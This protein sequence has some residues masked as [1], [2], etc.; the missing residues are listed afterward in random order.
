MGLIF[1]TTEEYKLL[2]FS[3]KKFLYISRCFTVFSKYIEI[4]NIPDF[5]LD[6][7]VF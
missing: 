2:K 5:A 3:S 6:M 7:F 1:S 4:W